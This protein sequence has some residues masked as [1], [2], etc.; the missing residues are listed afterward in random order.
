MYVEYETVGYE[1]FFDAIIDV[2]TKNSNYSITRDEITDGG[3]YRYVDITNTTHNFTLSYRIGDLRQNSTLPDGTP[4]YKQQRNLNTYYKDDS[5]SNIRSEFINFK[6]SEV[7]FPTFFIT[8]DLFLITFKTEDEGFYSNCMFKYLPYGDASDF[9]YPIGLCGNKGYV[10]SYTYAVAYGFERSYQGFIFND[11]K[12]LEFFQRTTSDD[13]F[14]LNTVMFTSSNS[15]SGYC[16][17]EIPG[18][19][20]SNSSKVTDRTKINFSGDNKKYVAL[21]LF[22]VEQL[23]IGSED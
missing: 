21:E 4:T 6:E 1:A 23:L 3:Y 20:I 12:S 22:N 10:S 8:D 18:F 7:L 2:A 15:D 14:L 5:G 16:F 9:P 13:T 17:G 19:F 11:L